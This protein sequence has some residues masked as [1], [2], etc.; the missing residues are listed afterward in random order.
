MGLND[1]KYSLSD[2]MPHFLNAH[3]HACTLKH[4]NMHRQRQARQQKKVVFDTHDMTTVRRP[5]VTVHC[6]NKNVK[7]TTQRST[8]E[9]CFPGCLFSYK[10]CSKI[11]IT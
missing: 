9:K 4:K 2:P 11:Q 1:R 8:L 5:T 3:A 10:L 6:E 7:T